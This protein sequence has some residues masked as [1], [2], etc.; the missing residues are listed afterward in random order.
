MT[1]VRADNPIV[2]SVNLN[3]FSKECDKTAP[4]LTSLTVNPPVYRMPRAA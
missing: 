4:V 1:T 2:G 3:L